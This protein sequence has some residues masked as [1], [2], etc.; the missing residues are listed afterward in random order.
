M[1]GL[2]LVKKSEW[3]KDNNRLVGLIDEQRI[4]RFEAEDNLKLEKKISAEYLNELRILRSQNKIDARTELLDVD[5]GDPT[6]DKVEARREYVARVAGFYHDILKP[7]CLQM[8]STFHRLTEEETNE[9]ETDLY[10]KMGIY[11]CREFMKWGDASI[12]E[13][14]ANQVQ[15]PETPEERKETIITNIVL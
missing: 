10:L 15:K 8:I 9:R 2:K 3:I 14:V 5:I 13:Q 12:N 4:A 6:P 11:I 1:F 7:K